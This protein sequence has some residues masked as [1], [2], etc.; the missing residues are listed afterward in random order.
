M[1]VLF[2][3]EDK[4]FK[5]LDCN[6][7]KWTLRSC[8]STGYEAIY[9]LKQDWRLHTIHKQFM[10]IIYLLNMYQ[11]SYQTLTGVS[12]SIY[13]DA[14]GLLSA[15]FARGIFRS[16]IQIK[17][18]KKRNFYEFGEEFL[19]ASYKEAQVFWCLM[20]KVLKRNKIYDQTNMT[21]HNTNVVS[22][23]TMMR[24]C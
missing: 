20:K 10:T 21:S 19:K 1:K 14:A 5:H 15:W 9:L 11:E 2:S 23:P 6:N 13:S 18:R 22:K 17:S 4:L 24:H 16:T 3:V 8:G 7:G 12:G